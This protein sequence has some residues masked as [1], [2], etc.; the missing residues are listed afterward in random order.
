LCGTTGCHRNHARKALKQALRSRILM[1]RR[2][3][4]FRYGSKVVAALIFCWAVLD[5]PAGKRWTPILGELVAILRRFGELDIDEDTATLLAG[6][7]A[8]TID[9]R[10]DTDRHRH[11]HRHRLDG[12]PPR[13]HKARKWVLAAFDDIAN[14]MPFPIL[15]VDSD[16]GS[17]FINHHLLARCEN[18]R[19]P[20]PGRGRAT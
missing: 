8:A 3:R 13:A 4:S 2:P 14:V 19:S 7:S 12:G 1:A 15:G 18:A 16:N 9:Q 10:L 11:R 20:A 5:M 17:E 6:M